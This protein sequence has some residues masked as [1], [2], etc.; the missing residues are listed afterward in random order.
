MSEQVL[1][2]SVNQVM[3]YTAIAN[4]LLVVVLAAINVY[5]AGHAKRQADA[6]KEQVD[7]FTRQAE[8]AAETLSL[9][10]KQM[11][12]QVRTDQAAVTL[13]LKVAIHVIEDWLKRIAPDRHPQL[14][15]QIVIMPADFSLATQRAHSIDPIAAE[16]MGAAA[17]YVGEAETN[18][19]I[20][21]SLEVGS[22]SA[23]DV[24]DKATKSLNTAKYKLSVAR[25]RWEAM[26]EQQP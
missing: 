22:H 11:D 18:L 16:N 12:Q 10:R 3:A 20:L 19:K 8:I 6:S 7:V 25:T 4:V 26:V 23:K 13:Q 2:L 21:R 1:G 24:L 5:Y 17:L 14:P 9:L 15:D